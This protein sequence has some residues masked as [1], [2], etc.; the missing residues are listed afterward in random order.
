MKGEIYQGVD[1]E[2]EDTT[3]GHSV[4]V[5][6]FGIDDGEEYYDIKNSEGYEWSNGG[7]RRDIKV[8]RLG[9]GQ[10]TQMSNDGYT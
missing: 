4:L 3:A 6:G 2:V 1:K 9:S 8:E 7:F 5:H 10:K